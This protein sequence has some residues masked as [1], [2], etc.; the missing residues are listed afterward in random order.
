MPDTCTY[1]KLFFFKKI[2]KAKKLTQLL[3]KPFFDATESLSTRSHL[4]TV[5]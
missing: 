2:L 1:F 3:E 5:L 4:L